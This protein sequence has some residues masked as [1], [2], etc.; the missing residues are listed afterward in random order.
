LGRRNCIIDALRL[1]LAWQRKKD[2]ALVRWG[3]I[4]H[5][6]FNCRYCCKESCCGSWHG[7]V[8]HLR[9]VDKLGLAIKFGRSFPKKGGKKGEA[10]VLM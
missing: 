1:L 7:Y 6:A 8:I 3:S 10:P 5:Y 9:F 4:C 2:D